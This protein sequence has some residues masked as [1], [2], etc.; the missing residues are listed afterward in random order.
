[1]RQVCRRYNIKTALQS[2]FTLC[3]Q[4]AWNHHHQV[5]WDMIKVLDKVAM[6]LMKV[7][8]HMVQLVNQESSEY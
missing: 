2:A 1:M 5:D 7:A 3:R 6:L 4:L 8:F